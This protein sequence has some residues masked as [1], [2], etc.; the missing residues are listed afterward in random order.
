MAFVEYRKDC[1]SATSCLP[2]NSGR[3]LPT[4]RF[5]ARERQASLPSASFCFKQTINQKFDRVSGQKLP[6]RLRIEM[7]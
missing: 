5:C 7:G 3:H 1:C 6:I 2:P 4:R